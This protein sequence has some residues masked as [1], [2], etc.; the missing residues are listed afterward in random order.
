MQTGSSFTRALQGVTKREV[1]LGMWEQKIRFHTG[2]RGAYSRSIKGVGLPFAY[3]A[4][5]P[6]I[7]MSLILKAAGRP[8]IVHRHNRIHNIL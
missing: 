4:I 6:N 1:F 2:L 3:F 7:P 5:V 8:A